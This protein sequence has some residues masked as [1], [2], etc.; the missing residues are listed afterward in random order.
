M[1]CAA[2][3]LMFRR[4]Q[5][6]IEVLLVHPGGPLW[7]NR[8]L[9][10]WTMPKGMFDPAEETPLEAAKREFTEETGFSANAAF[11]DLGSIVQPSGKTVHAFAVEGDADAAAARSNTFEMEWPPRS[12]SRQEFPE[13]DRAQWFALDEA[14]RKLLKGQVGFVGR[15][16]AKLGDR[17]EDGGQGTSA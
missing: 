14:R 2:G 13:V 5:H 16:A 1:A 17:A 6:G 11:L 3:L 15:L 8:D 7:E 12:G 10:A 9:G 4:G